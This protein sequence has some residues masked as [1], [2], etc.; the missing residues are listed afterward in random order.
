MND[1]KEQK[2]VIVIEKFEPTITIDEIFEDVKEHV[3]SEYEVKIE[4]ININYHSNKIRVFV[5][6]TKKQKTTPVFITLPKGI[7]EKL[8][9]DRKA[10]KALITIG[11]AV[12]NALENYYEL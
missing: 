11:D 8:N 5:S 9:G 12:V 3:G 7:E 10:D 6:F 4:K 2:D 1:N